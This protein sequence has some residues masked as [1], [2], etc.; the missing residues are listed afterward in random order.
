MGSSNT[1]KRKEEDRW[2]DLGAAV[3]ARMRQLALSQ[4][5]VEQ[6]CGVSVF[7]VRRLRSGVAANYWEVNLTKVSLALGWTADS[8]ERILGGKPPLESDG[9]RAATTGASG[10]EVVIARLSAIEGRIAAV[11]EQ[12]ATY[13]RSERSVI[14]PSEPS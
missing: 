5:G 12:I 3:T 10:I 8:I 2:D 9:S 4:R 1:R 11:E 13:N 14:D 6:T 7:T